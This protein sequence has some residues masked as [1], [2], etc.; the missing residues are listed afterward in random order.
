[1]S[2]F[3]AMNGAVLTSTT[4]DL[5][6][7]L[8]LLKMKS[9]NSLTTIAMI[10][11]SNMKGITKAA[12]KGQPRTAPTP[13]QKMPS[14]DLTPPLRSRKAAV[15]SMAVYMAKLEGRYA[16]PAW[17]MPVLVAMMIMKK[18]AM[19]GLTALKRTSNSL[20]SA[21]EHNKPRAILKA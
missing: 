21:A 19:R 3:V 13:N 16:V 7:P 1:M 17:N 4:K 11:S 20:V 6:V 2:I 15:P 14:A 10:N 9:P 18:A 12:A 5:A 8:M